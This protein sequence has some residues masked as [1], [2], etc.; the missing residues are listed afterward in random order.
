DGAPGAA[1]TL[2]LCGSWEHSPPC[3]LAA[4][5]THPVRD[6]KTVDLRVVFATE[7]EHQNEVRR[8]IDGALRAGAAT[9]PNGVTSHWAL[10][11]SN[12]GILTPSERAQALRMS[13][14]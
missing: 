4:H 2:A 12:P 8:R 13:G 14:P 10:R 9:D 11:G 3:P 6:G 5:H 7:P 1:I